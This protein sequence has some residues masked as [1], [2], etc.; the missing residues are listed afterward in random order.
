[1]PANL[2][3]PE[4]GKLG[5]G[6][7]DGGEAHFTNSR[8]E[9]ERRSTCMVIPLD[10]EHQVLRFKELG[11]DAY[12]AWR[13][14]LV[15]QQE[16]ERISAFNLA[17]TYEVH[18]RVG[19]YA[20]RTVKP[21]LRDGKSIVCRFLDGDGA[22]EYAGFDPRDLVEHQ[23]S[24]QQELIRD[25]LLAMRGMFNGTHGAIH[26]SSFDALVRRAKDLEVYLEDA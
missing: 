6:F 24:D 26:R 14:E 9:A 1:M 21:I 13:L 16:R 12:V 7:M 22:S 15:V 20:G 18:E 3:V 25:L 8:T 10:T 11:A 17:K 19:Q 2:S 4:T 5:W 23:L